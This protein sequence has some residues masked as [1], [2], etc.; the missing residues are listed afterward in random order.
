MRFQITMITYGAQSPEL[1][2]RRYFS[3][4][5]RTTPTWTLVNLARVR[6]LTEFN[7]YR[8][9]VLTSPDHLHTQVLHELVELEQLKD[10]DI[11]L[12]VYDTFD[13]T[14]TYLLER[15]AEDDMRI[16][17]VISDEIRTRNTLCEAH[18][19]SHRKL[20]GAAYVWILP[21]FY[22]THWWRLSQHQINNLRPTQRCSNYEMR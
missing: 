17:I 12:T 21:L 11:E 7:W 9:A 13:E 5:Y 22:D 2:N 18:R 8:C 20:T 14:A 15:A 4:L 1:S 19:N 6:L 3:S 16:F 10:S